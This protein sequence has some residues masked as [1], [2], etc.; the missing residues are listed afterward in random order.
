MTGWYWDGWSFHEIPWLGRIQ[1]KDLKNLWIQWGSMKNNEHWIC[2][3]QVSHC[4]RERRRF[5]L[6]LGLSGST[7]FTT[8]RRCAAVSDWHRCRKSC[9][10]FWFHA[11]FF[12][13]PKNGNRKYYNIYMI[14]WKWINLSHSESNTFR[15][16]EVTLTLESD[17]SASTLFENVRCR[18]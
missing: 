3:K 12:K 4:H 7:G 8:R 2:F 13:Q 11:F 14:F 15:H 10:V 9:Y 16:R 5:F 1:L 6:R 17:G 18:G